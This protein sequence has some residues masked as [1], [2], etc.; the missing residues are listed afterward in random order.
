MPKCNM[1][2]CQSCD[3]FDTLREQVMNFKMFYDSSVTT[4]SRFEWT[5]LYVEL[6]FF[7][8]YE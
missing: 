8:F 7:H 5:K 6:V 2:F 4:D 1:S 3:E